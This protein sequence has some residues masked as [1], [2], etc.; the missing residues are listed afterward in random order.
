MSELDFI[1]FKL[2]PLLMVPGLQTGS[3]TFSD[4]QRLTDIKKSLE[5]SDMPEA[6]P[7]IGFRQWIKS[8]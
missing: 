6:L 8:R 7:A 1:H 5:K 4:V 3:H 2:E